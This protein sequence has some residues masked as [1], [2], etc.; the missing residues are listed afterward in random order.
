M[1]TDFWNNFWMVIVGILSLGTSIVAIYLAYK[2]NKQVEKQIELSNKQFL[3]EKRIEVY[4]VIDE[5]EIACSTTLNSKN[6]LTTENIDNLLRSI[7]LIEYFE[8]IDNITS[9]EVGAESLE[10]IHLLEKYIDVLKKLTLISDTLIMVFYETEHL[11]VVSRFI[12]AY[13]NLLRE[14]YEYYRTDTSLNEVQNQLHN[15][16]KTLNKMKDSD[17]LGKLRK[18]IKLL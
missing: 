15:L 4:N 18:S 17:S 16:E 6:K 11:V 9:I 13:H 3:F 7:T 10:D 1:E 2:A 12:I 8:Q 14:I 5:I